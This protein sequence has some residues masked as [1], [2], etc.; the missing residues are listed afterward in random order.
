M[1]KIFFVKILFCL[2]FFNLFSQNHSVDP[3]FNTIDNGFNSGAGIIG[4]DP[5]G[6]MIN[7]GEFL[8][9]G[10]DGLITMF[11]GVNVN[12]IFKTLPNGL[13]DPSFNPGLGLNGDV[14]AMTRQLDGK[15]LLGGGFLAYNGNVVNGMVRILPNGQIDTTFNTGTGFNA[16]VSAIEIM[17]DGRILVGGA[18]SEYNNTP[19]KNLIRLFPDGTLD[20][21]L[22][23]NFTTSLVHKVKVLQNG[24]MLIR[25]NENSTQLVKSITQIDANGTRDFSFDFSLNQPARDFYI[26]D[27]NNILV[28]G[29]F[30]VQGSYKGLVKLNSN[31]M[32]DL[33]FGFPFFFGSVSDLKQK[34]DGS[35]V[36]S[37]S[38]SNILGLPTN[39]C[40]FV[41]TPQRTVDTTYKYA[42]MY[43]AFNIFQNFVQSDGKI[44]V[45]GNFSNFNNVQI[46]RLLRINTDGSLDSSFFYRTGAAYAATDMVIDRQN[47]IIISGRNALTYNNSRANNLIRIMPDGNIDVSFFK[48]KFWN[49]ALALDIQQDDKILV[50]GTDYRVNNTSIYNNVLRLNDDGSIDSTFMMSLNYY[51]SNTGLFKTIKQLSNGTIIVGGDFPHFRGEYYKNLVLLNAD[52]SINA[53]LDSTRKFNGAV[54]KIIEDQNGKIVVIGDF[55]HYNGQLHSKIIRFNSDF[56][57]DATFVTGQG[58]ST[59]GVTDILEQPDGKYVVSGPFFW[60]N[61]HSSQGVIRIK[62]NG[63]VDS[64]FIRNHQFSSPIKSMDIQTDGKIVVGGDFISSAF[65]NFKYFARL[66]TDGTID[67][68]FSINNKFNNSIT[69][70]KVDKVGKIVAAGNFTGIE[71]VGRNRLAKILNCTNTYYFE[72]NLSTCDSLSWRD[73]ITYYTD[74]NSAIFNPRTFLTSCDSIYALKLQVNYSAYNTDTIYKCDDYTWVNGQTYTQSNYT[75]KVIYTAQNGCDSIVTLNLTIDKPY[76]DTIAIFGNLLYVK[77][78]NVNYQWINCATNT[79]IHGETNRYMELP[80]SGIFAVILSLNDC[81]YI[82]ECFNVNG[83]SVKNYTTEFS[84]F[85][86]PVTDQLTILRT[87]NYNSDA[88]LKIYD[89]TGK[90]VYTQLINTNSIQVNVQDFNSGVYLLEVRSQNNVEMIKL[91]KR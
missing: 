69:K 1:N 15:I 65:G 59:S 56:T 51:N 43:G 10:R 71:N 8:I 4:G 16:F 44:V 62:N 49:T 30:T 60:Y 82:S 45:M 29:G 70:I 28:T 48:S 74:N 63:D 24:K 76:N 41:T 68:L 55:T 78:E 37:G 7:D 3:T 90:L 32:Y 25:C 39:T 17:A 21:T 87:S 80:D 20:T 77:Q 33:T 91:I 79:P 73:G 35:Y 88:N 23:L 75:D 6:V 26:D 81:E 9:A 84:V 2:S 5:I 61:Q 83:T 67:S 18:F 47:R 50:T 31:G 19:C 27:N 64:S 89:I 34:T 57:I 14:L 12:G 54:N 72:D 38:I 52:G 13:L 66:N 11:N 22:Q 86:N 85:P 40:F 42:A 46:N 36:L 53:S 58:F